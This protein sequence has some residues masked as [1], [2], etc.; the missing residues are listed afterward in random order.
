MKGIIYK[1]TF[2]NGKVYIGQTRRPQEQRIA[3]HFNEKTGQ[4][5]PG[6]WSAYKKYG[7]PDYSVL[8]EAERDDEDE[9]VALLNEKET[10]YIAMYKA[11]NPEYGYNIR[12]WGTE[13]SNTHRIVHE[14]FHE[15]M[16]K[17]KE[18]KLELYNKA[19]NKIYYTKEPLTEEEDYLLKYKYP[20]NLMC[21][22]SE[23][24]LNKYDSYDEENQF[25]IDEGLE[26]VKFLIEDEAEEDTVSYIN[27]NFDKIK[28]GKNILQI[29]KEGNVV[30]EYVSVNEICNVLNLKR[31]DNI[32]NV[33]TGKQK[34]AYGYFWKYNKDLSK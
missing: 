7:E 4:S 19:V 30:K 13:R 29:D 22:L 12:S 14:K 26:Y 16:D 33:L 24:D 18:S 11:D 34:T 5:N 9:L 8:F 1:Y 6:F 25:I 15:H 21:N 10:L 20:E 28:R 3:E 17:V 23:Y 27:K 2:K 32:R 31:G